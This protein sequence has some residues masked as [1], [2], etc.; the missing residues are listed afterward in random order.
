MIRRVRGTTPEIEKAARRMRQALTPAGPMLWEAL[1]ERR[2]AG[3]RFRCQHQV[4]R[5][6]FDF[7]DND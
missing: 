2:L 5:F 4:D 6:I 1:R 3:L 7:Y